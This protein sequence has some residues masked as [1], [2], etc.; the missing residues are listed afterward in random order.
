MRKRRAL[1]KGDGESVMLKFE[2]KES[3]C[4]FR[5]NCVDSHYKIEVPFGEGSHSQGRRRRLSKYIYQKL[6]GPPR[7]Y[8]KVSGLTC[9]LIVQPHHGSKSPGPLD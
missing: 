7:N 8:M 4:M 1:L 3:G 5:S 2:S 9:P 6:P